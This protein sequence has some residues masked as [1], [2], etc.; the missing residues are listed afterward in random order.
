MNGVALMR[1]AA[2]LGAECV[3]ATP[4]NEVLAAEVGWNVLVD[5]RRELGARM[6]AHDA[7]HDSL[8]TRLCRD[9]GLDDAV[10]ILG[11]KKGLELIESQPGVGAVIVDADNRVHISKRLEGVVHIGRPPSDGP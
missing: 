1:D 2:I 5:R 11:P 7:D 9:L 8:R 4:A 10:F 3:V 6:R